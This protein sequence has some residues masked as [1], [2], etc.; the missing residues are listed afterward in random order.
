MLI[1]LV[2]DESRCLWFRIFYEDTVL[3]LSY[4]TMLYYYIISACKLGVLTGFD[5]GGMTCYYYRNSINHWSATNNRGMQRILVLTIA[6]IFICLALDWRQYWM[7]RTPNCFIPYLILT[8]LKKQ[9]IEFLFYPWIFINQC[10]T[11]HNKQLWAVSIWLNC[12]LK[13]GD[14][15]NVNRQEALDIKD[16][17]QIYSY[18]LDK[19][20]LENY[21]N[22]Y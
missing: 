19:L 5:I 21:A 1:F 12:L 18:E 3:I 16:D 9:I 10:W 13:H 4:Y 2:V 17:N 7:N 14:F 6:S 11:K 22:L 15:S 8:I 20:V